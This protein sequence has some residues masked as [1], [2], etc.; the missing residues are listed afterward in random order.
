MTDAARGARG[1]AVVLAGQLVRLIVQLLGT[2]VLSRLLTPDDFGV[3]AMV[4]VFVA[5]GDLLRDFGL[6]SASLQVKNLTH[7]QASNL[8]WVNA[9]LAGLVSAL[10]ALSAPLLGLLFDEPRL[11]E[12]VP[13]MAIATLLNGLQAQ[14]QVQLARS[15]RFR[16]LA[17]T[18]VA[19][20]TCG[21]GLAILIALQ[22]GGYWSLVVQ[23][24]STAAVLLL[25]RLLMSGFV[26]SRPRRGFGSMTLMKAGFDYGL[27]QLMRFTTNNLDSVLIGASSGA[28][29][30][31]Y[32][33]RAFQVYNMPRLGLLDPLTNVAV[34][35]LN[36][37]A[38]KS[39]R[40]A[41]SLLIKTQF[42]ILLGVN[43]VFVAI[44]VTASSLVAI[45]LG[46]QWSDS[47]LFLQILCIAGCVQPFNT[48]SYWAFMLAENSRAML[49]IQFVTRPLSI[50]LMVAAVPFGATWIAIAYS[51][52]FVI[53]WPITY[54][55]QRRYTPYGSRDL[56][57]DGLRVIGASVAAFLVGWSVLNLL[58]FD[59]WLRLFMGVVVVLVVMTLSI[60]VVPGGRER[61]ARVI[62][63]VRNLFRRK[64]H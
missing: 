31:G 48:A 22:G 23:V 15:M 7:Q 9:S 58:P 5:L 14:H 18:D 53:S 39:P 52:G 49:K 4:A 45:V 47:V 16:A 17:L 6:V 62:R 37:V 25:S 51:A 28:A 33:N 21:V 13:A 10:I 40:D 56:L 3:V 60:L 35:M 38:A 12:I 24:V 42:V 36:E 55:W 26:P 54:I 44:A 2:I 34:P 41:E 19:A 29:A 32:Y 43:F 11:L 50:I 27:A 64:G 59:V 8:F 63:V 57:L 61:L 1:G 20:Q 30:L 46:P